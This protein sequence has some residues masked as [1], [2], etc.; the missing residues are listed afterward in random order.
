MVTSWQ[1][2]E[3]EVRAHP[4]REAAYYFDLSRMRAQMNLL[5]HLPKQ[6]RTFYAM[7]VNP[8]S[9][10]VRAALRHSSITGIE[11]ASGGE[12]DTVMS[13]SIK[14]IDVLEDIIYTGPG[15]KNEELQ[16][17]VSG[18][19]RH[20]NVESEL[21]AR[22]L[23]RI[24]KEIGI[25]QPILVRLNTKHKIEGAGVVLGSGDTQF[26]FPQKRAQDT[27]EMLSTLDNIR[28]DGFHMYPATGVVDYNKLLGSVEASFEFLKDI[29]NSSQREFPILDFGG[30]FGI[31]YSGEKVFN[32]KGYSQGLESLITDFDFG[33]KIFYLEL[34]RYLAADMGYYV[35]RVNDIKTLESGKK[36]VICNAGTN[37]HKRPQVLDVDYPLEV[38]SM[39]VEQEFPEMQE[40]IVSPEDVFNVYGPFCTSVDHVAL[41]KTGKLIRVGDYVVQPKAGAYGKTMSPQRFLSHPEVPEII[42]N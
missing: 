28:V 1:K 16:L 29:E 9:E 21:E 6:V 25:T 3:A 10:V 12:I 33:D 24:A 8:H 27:L 18:R 35:T 26:G 11:V 17:S 20:V 32:I 22:R 39:N 30:G 7:K 42:L 23:N 2:L 34:G 14:G 13:Q 37:A 41:G 15:K 19:I 38:I 36:A 31:D 5:K 40:I 4:Q